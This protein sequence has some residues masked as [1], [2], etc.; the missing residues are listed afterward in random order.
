MPLRLAAIVSHPIQY[1]APLFRLVAA[2]PGVDLE[3][4]FLSDHGLAPTFDQG[5]GRSVQFDVPLLD[6]YASR[7]VPNRAWK[8]SVARAGG[9]VNPGLVREIVRGKY[10]AVW[11]HGYGHAS[12]WLAFAA[13]ALTRTPVLLRGESTLLYDSPPV[14]RAAKKALVGPLVRAAAGLLYIGA[15]NRSFYESLGARPE[16]LFFAPYAVDN[17]WFA[18]RADEARANGRREALRA[19]VGA[20]ADDVVLLFVGKLLARK[21][22]EDVAE[23]VARLGPDGRRA[24]IAY[25][26]E[27][28]ARASLEAALARTGVRGRIVGFANQSELPAWY[29]ASDLFVLPSEHETWGLVVN[30]AMAAGLPVVA[31]DLVGSSY[32][33]VVGR[34]TGAVHR[35]GDP[36]SLAEALRPLVADRAARAAASERARAVVAGYDVSVTAAGI[37]QALQAA[38]GRRAGS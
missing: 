10:D 6:G 22:P 18:A 20:T 19:G 15:Q 33:L 11:V 2:T 31:S 23:A 24:V 21:R 29:A 30:E 3:V 12:E 28:E 34:G 14:R 17:G 7:F 36:A 25:V 32:D 13:A 1:Q 38:A 37:V 8:P 5:F 35:A 26:G 27:G 4:L 9:L 16:Q